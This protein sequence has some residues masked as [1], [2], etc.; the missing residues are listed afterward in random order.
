M[1]SL[2]SLTPA[3]PTVAEEPAVAN[4]SK[5][6]QSEEASIGGVG[7]A[8]YFRYLK[9]VG[10]LFVVLISF[11]T[12]LTQALSIYGNTWLSEWSAHPTANEP[13][14]RAVYL[15]V[16]GAIGALQGITLFIASIFSAYGSLK[17]ARVLHNKM[18]HT[19]M[20]LPMSFFDTTPLGRIANRCVLN[21]L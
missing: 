6:I 19:S 1:V 17:A 3:T 21:C 2:D 5:L 10:A 7:L 20:R 16:Y 15:G 11:G 18:L 8:V 9:S 4:G 14:T 12:I 13:Y